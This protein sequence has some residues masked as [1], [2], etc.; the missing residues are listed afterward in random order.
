MVAPGLV[1]RCFLIAIQGL[2]KSERNAAYERFARND[3]QVGILASHLQGLHE[4]IYVDN[5]P[6]VSIEDLPDVMPSVYA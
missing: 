1:N 3:P 2:N 6:R 5:P 4:P